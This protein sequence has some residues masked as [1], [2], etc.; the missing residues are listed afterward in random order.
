MGYAKL[1]LKG[2]IVEVGRVGSFRR[3][4]NTPSRTVVSLLF[5]DEQ[6]ED[7]R[8]YIVDDDATARAF[9]ANL[10]GEITITLEAGE[11][12]PRAG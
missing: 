9:A 12:P 4:P 6:N 7:V 10:Y 1:V 5:E 3:N 11:K 2:K 8:R